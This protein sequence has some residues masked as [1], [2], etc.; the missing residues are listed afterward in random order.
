M[1]ESKAYNHSE[2][3]TESIRVAVDA[4]GGDLAPEEPVKGALTAAEAY[5]DTEIILVGRSEIIQAELDKSPHT[6]SN[7]GIKEAPEV[8][9]MHES[10]VAALRNKK[11]SSISIGVGLV[12]NSGADAFVSAGNTGAMV[13]ASTLYLGLIP[14]VLRPGIAVPVTA[15]DHPALIIDVGA[16]INCKPA[17]LLQYGLM[18]SIFASEVMGMENPRVGLLNVG[19]EARKGTKL[20]KDAFSLLEKA[21]VNFVGNV[22]AN[23][24]FF[25]GCDILVCEGFTGNVMLKTCESLMQKIMEFL[26]GEIKSSLRRKIGFLLCKDVFKATKQAADYAEYGGA[27]LLGVDGVIIISHGRSDAKAIKNAV[28]EARSALKLDV[29]RDI[30]NILGQVEDTE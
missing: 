4:F 23:D 26:E 7:I 14:G 8:V 27:V 11:T 5:P 28:R 12:K 25:H 24:I 1:S 13:A 3:N 2:S 15:I 21:P 29:N 30:V 20:Q 6:P 10:P 19:E 18:A 17:H 22:E 9:G 16:N